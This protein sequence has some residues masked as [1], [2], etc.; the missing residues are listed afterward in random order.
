MSEQMLSENESRTSSNRSANLVAGLLMIGL[1]AVGFNEIDEAREKQESATGLLDLAIEDSRYY[2][3][4]DSRG[5]MDSAS[6]SVSVITNENHVVELESVQDKIDS[7][8]DQQQKGALLVCLGAVGIG[9]AT[10]RQLYHL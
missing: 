6:D 7:A 4:L 2:R 1:A 9:V 3:V 8:D 10:T 5:A